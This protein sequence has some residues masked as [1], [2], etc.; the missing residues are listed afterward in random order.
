MV[1]A[2]GSGKT[3]FGRQLADVLSVPFVEL[4]SIFHQAGW[5][6]LTT[7]EFRERVADAIRGEDWV[8]D[9]SYGAVSDLVWARADTV[10]WLDLP[11]RVIMRRVIARTMRRALTREE[12]WNGNREPLTNFYRWDP[13]R[14]IIRWAW[15]KYPAYVGAYSRSMDHPPAP[16]LRF[17]RLAS[18]RDARELI[19]T[20]RPG[21]H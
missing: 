14:N 13:E 12:L 21:G 19:R 17:I 2:P 5:A 6:D 9:G 18:G 3:T 11:R 16:G 10:I 8:V 1:G 15:V 20:L 4:D 7:G